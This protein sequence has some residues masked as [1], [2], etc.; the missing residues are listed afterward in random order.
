MPKRPSNAGW[1]FTLIRAVAF[2][3][4]CA[5][6]LAISSRLVQGHSRPWSEIVAA[7]V[8]SLGAFLLTTIF[9]KFEGLDLRK[10]GVLA[11]RQ[12]TIR[13]LTGFI[14]GLL[15][16]GTQCALVL[17]SGHLALIHV[18]GVDMASVVSILLL[19]FALSSREE[20]AFH[21]YPLRSL[22]Y[23]IG[24]WQAQLIVALLFSVEH[25]IGG[26]SWI[27]ALLGAGVGSL[28]FGIAS[29]KTKGVALPIGMHAAWNFGQWSLGLKNE[30]GIWQVVV[31]RGYE[32][33]LDT[34]ET[35]SYLIVMGLAILA[36]YFIYPK[37]SV[38]RSQPQ[39]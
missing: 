10:V 9:V 25:V 1:A 16:A 34:I 24:A 35:L 37:T 18:Q 28:L 13:V 22:K 11:G 14:F 20:F 12:T 30:P 19:Y 39:Y 23:A 38:R 21:G 36:F 15:L 26:V 7:S 32:S 3:L 6:V 4:C 2:C 29:L 33:R 17:M 5:V 31:K 8:A 27:H